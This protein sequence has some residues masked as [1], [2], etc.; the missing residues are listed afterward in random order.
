MWRAETLASARHAT[1]ADFYRRR[2]FDVGIQTN[3][4][5]IDD[6][7]RRNGIGILTYWTGGT[8]H[9]VTVRYIPDGEYPGTFV[10]YNEGGQGPRNMS[11]WYTSLD[12]W[13]GRRDYGPWSLITMR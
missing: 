6:Q 11:S 7:I 5:N 8:A 3:P 13:L 12:E 9:T 2:G 4:Q 1:V 10:V